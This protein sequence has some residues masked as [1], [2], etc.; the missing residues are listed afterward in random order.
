MA[1]IRGGLDRLVAGQTPYA[2]FDFGT[3]ANPM[4]YLPVTFLSYVPAY[5]LGLDL[6]SV[7]F[8]LSLA[9][10]GV[11]ALTLR[12]LAVPAEVRQGALLALAV[13]YALPLS[14]SLDVQTEWQVFNFALV[15][16][17]CLVALGR[18]RLAAVSYGLALAA[19]PVALF[20]AAPLVAYALRVRPRAEVGW[21]T[22]IV[23]GVAALPIIPFL[24]WD[25]GAFIWAV[26]YVPREAWGLTPTLN[27]LPYE[28]PYRFLW[29]DMPGLRLV[30]L[31]LLVGFGFAAWRYARQAHTLIALSAAS[32]L[33]LVVTSG[34]YIGPHMFTVVPL[35]VL[36]A[37][38]ARPA[39]ADLQAA[40][41][42]AESIR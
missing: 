27:T 15:G 34:S 7:G 3:H 12:G 13:F 17:F 30:Q 23:A 36:L 31:A 5:L 42:V 19:M 39:S 16:V 1:V 6:H 41:A 20:C 38:V 33:A 22:L 25:A 18:L 26:S 35:L 10:L 8:G 14:V 32:Y 29:A 40:T 28:W 11:L 24:A 21:L 9:L 37:D 4:P 2:F